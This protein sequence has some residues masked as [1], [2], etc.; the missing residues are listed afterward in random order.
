MSNDCIFC[1]IIDGDLPSHKVYE[2]KD[3]TAFLDIFPVSRGHTVVVPRIHC[4]NFLDFPDDKIEV[5]FTVLKKLTVELKGKLGADGVNILQNN[6]TAAGQL[7]NHMHFHIIP[8]W[9]DD[10]ALKL[11]QTKKQAKP[12]ELKEILESIVD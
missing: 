5:Y 8:R 12:E 7:V 2:D 3:V 1:K 11:I 9:D 6:F 4:L 10:G